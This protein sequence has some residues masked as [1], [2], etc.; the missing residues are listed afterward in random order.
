[1][2]STHDGLKSRLKD[3]QSIR[4]TVPTS[5][6]DTQ[7]CLPQSDVN[8]GQSLAVISLDVCYSQL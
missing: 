6:S 1:M 7:P 2:I 8:S 5:A 3:G 4:V